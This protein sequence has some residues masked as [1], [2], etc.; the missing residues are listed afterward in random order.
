MDQP[1]SRESPRAAVG[2]T[3]VSTMSDRDVS[4]DGSSWSLPSAPAGT[5]GVSRRHNGPPARRP[6]ARWVCPRRRSRRVRPG[7]GTPCRVGL[8]AAVVHGHQGA[9]GGQPPG[10]RPSDAREALVTSAALPANAAMARSLWSWGRRSGVVGSGRAVGGGCGAGVLHAHGASPVAWI[11]WRLVGAA[12]GAAT[13]GAW[14]S[15]QTSRTPAHRPGGLGGC[16]GWAHKG[17]AD[18]GLAGRTGEPMLRR[19][20]AGRPVS[21]AGGSGRGRR[22]LAPRGRC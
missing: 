19:G 20:R 9:V 10:D 22:P 7:P 15:A 21:A 6:A 12:C 18:P 17:V 16:A 14:T 3:V 1:D 4:A 13:W 2:A 5:R 8:V 11:C